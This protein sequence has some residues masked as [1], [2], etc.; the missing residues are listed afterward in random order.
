MLYA[1]WPIVTQ[2]VRQLEAFPETYNPGYFL[3]KVALAALALLV[4]LQA[5]VDIARE[6]PAEPR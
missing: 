3:V 2:S 4:L 6:P 1:S 5:L